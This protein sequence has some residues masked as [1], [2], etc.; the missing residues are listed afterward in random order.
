MNPHHPL[1]KVALVQGRHD[2]ILSACRGKRVLH[3]G[4][5]DSGLLT[6]RFAQNTLMHQKIA[7]VADG[8]WGV[9]IDPDGIKFLSEHG[10]TNLYIADLCALDEVEALNGQVFDVIVASEVIEHLLNPGL[11]LQSV[12]QLMLPGHTCLIISVPNAFRVDTLLWLLHGDEYVHPDHNYWFSYATICNLVQKS[13]FTI[14]DFYVY[15]FQSIHLLPR[16]SHRK[17]EGGRPEVPS[18]NN[19]GERLKRSIWAR[20]WIYIRSLPKRILVSFLYRQTHFWGDGLIL[21]TGLDKDAE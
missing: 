11:F 4:C 15:T 18:N 16:A 20:A 5:V 14:H 1:P 8:L 7:E 21:F 19:P 12:K 6:Q 3:L 13:G 17:M 9:D 10:F 2:I